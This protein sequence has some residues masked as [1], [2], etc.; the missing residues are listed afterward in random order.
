MRTAIIFAALAAAAAS[1]ATAAPLT[2]EMQSEVRLSV[3]S[4][5]NAAMQGRGGPEAGAYAYEA[6]EHC[7]RASKIVAAA[8]P[9]PYYLGEV[10]RCWGDAARTSNDHA[11]CDYWL[12]ARAYYSMAGARGPTP[13]S[14]RTRLAWVAADLAHACAG[15]GGDYA[16]KVKRGE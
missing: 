6:K 8:D 14:V 16:L 7:E 2:P 13:N 15:A 12:E 4:G 9:D 5:S 1:G 3:A 10:S 11:A